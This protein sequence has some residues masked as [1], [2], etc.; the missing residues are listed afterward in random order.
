MNHRRL[1]DNNLFTNTKP[2][3]VHVHVQTTGG[4]YDRIN[5]KGNFDLLPTVY[6]SVVAINLV[7]ATH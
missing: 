5:T 4:T 6:Y 2:V 3:Q 1:F 7:V